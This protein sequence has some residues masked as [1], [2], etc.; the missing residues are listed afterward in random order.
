MPAAA[1]AAR[2]GLPL[3]SLGLFGALAI[4][5]LTNRP[6]IAIAIPAV[7]L[8]AIACVR[9]PAAAVVGVFLLSGL[10]GTITA[11]TPIPVGPLAD[12]LLLG[13]WTG[14]V[15]IYLSGGARRTFWLWPALLAPLLYLAV[16]L[17]A[18]LLVD[19]FADGFR[20]FRAAAWYMAALPLLAVAPLS[21]ETHVRIAK[22]IVA[23]ALVVGTYVVFRWI[24]G[25]S[26]REILVAAF[27]QIERASANRFFGSFLSPFQL[28]LWTGTMIPFLFA[29]AL[30]FRGRWRLVAMAAIG[31]MGIGLFASDVRTGLVAMVVGLVVVLAVYLVSPAFPGRLGVGIAALL[32][33]AVVGAVGYGLTIGSSDER[34][35]RYA[36]ILDPSD[37]KAYTGRL[38]V[39]DEALEEMADAP[40]GHGLG[41]AGG[42]ASGTE[43]GREFGP[44]AS[45]KLDSA[46]LKVGL[47]QGFA[48]MVLFAVGMLVLL[49]GMALRAVRIRDREQAALVIGGA[50][51]LA[52]LI[53]FFYAGLYS[54]GLPVVAAWLLV[55]L[56]VAQATLRSPRGRPPGA[57]VGP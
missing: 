2:F 15:G 44:L 18:I 17:F 12:Y 47:E 52:S 29:F 16:T 55:G 33:A 37:D 20:A 50:G 19:P 22:G 51:A 3:L 41:T 25:S 10:L 31:L 34:A 1:G 56:G 53:I 35:A 43:A 32:A 40:W 54:E 9:R 49:S 46:Y 24:V 7:L 36:G 30:A 57:P 14:V 8:G 6:L 27:A 45:P 42:A 39:W 5:V 38:E 26:Q 11:F 4:S 13:L 48:V 23:V 28:A 21:R